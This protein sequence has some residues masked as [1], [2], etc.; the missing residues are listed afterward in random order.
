MHVLVSQIPSVLNVHVKTSN[1]PG[2]IFD[3]LAKLI[4]AIPTADVRTV[5][6]SIICITSLLLSKEFLSPIITRKAGRKISVPYDLILVSFPLRVRFLKVNIQIILI[7]TLSYQFSWRIPIVGDVPRGFPQPLLPVP[8]LIIDSISPAIAMT[9]VTLTLHIS[10]TKMF[11]KQL[12][13]KVDPGQEIYAL[14][15]TSLISGFF[16]TYPT[17][18]GLSRTLVG[19]ENR[20]KTQ[21]A[22]VST[23]V[24]LLAIILYIGPFF[25]HLPICVLSSVIIVALRPMIM[26]F[27]D[28]PK[29][30]HLSKYDCVR[31]FVIIVKINCLLHIN[32]CFR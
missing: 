13:Y 25:K 28:I 2:F 3:L 27:K 16:P 20:G 22:A 12:G 5:F 21:F 24:L 26:K 23:C 14:G 10:I 17:S 9:I 11:A 1:G 32:V 15:F 31:V 19:I 8:K 30:W 18:P 29:L 4:R 6:L 7:T